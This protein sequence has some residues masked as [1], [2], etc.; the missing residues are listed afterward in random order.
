MLR[1]TCLILLLILIIIT[2]SC[3]LDKESS[4]DN[5]I[6]VITEGM[7]FQSVDTIK[8][9]WNAFRYINKSYETHF[10]L[11]NKYP[12]GKSIKDNKVEII[13]PFQNGMDLIN[14]GKTEEGIA[15]FNKLPKW[16]FDVV[17]FGGSGL[18]SPKKTSLTYL[19]LDP[20]YYIME[21][22]VKMENGKFHT[23]MG[24]VKPLVVIDE[25]N[26]ISLPVADV[27]IE[28]SSTSGISISSEILK[29]D[30]TFSVHFKDQIVH[31]NF[32]GHDVNLVR[33]TNK[34]D[35]DELEEWMNWL[36][37]K[38]LITPSPKGITFLGGVNEMTAGNI[39][40]FK[41]NLEPGSYALIS[42]V[43]N[44]STKKMLKTFTISE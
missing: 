28:I 2:E 35:L 4:D 3:G 42:E 6:E 25:K 14:E 34:K 20:G 33:Y 31:E 13:P 12:E 24:M 37:P 32:V 21:C 18:I 26:D 17:Y 19:K 7:D 43:P 44:A 22:Y 38:G 40:Y 15:E 8:S 1:A 16:F 9:D 36:N 39:G 41:V 27:K 23:A 5:V 30:Q 29:G 11:L 10:F